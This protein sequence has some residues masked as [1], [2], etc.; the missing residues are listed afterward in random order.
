MPVSGSTTQ[1][2]QRW[3]WGLHAHASRPGVIWRARAAAK[4]SERLCRMVATVALYGCHAVV[5][6][7]VCAKA[8][9]ARQLLGGGCPVA[10][11]ALACM[12]C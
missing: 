11:Q 6:S 12:A 9:H 3:G 5:A 8:R 1:Q 4:P 7:L 10:P 2:S